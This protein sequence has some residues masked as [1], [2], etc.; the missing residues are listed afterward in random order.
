MKEFRQLTVEDTA[1][2]HKVL[3]DGYALL[4]IFQLPLMPS[5][6]P[7]KNL[8]SGLKTILYMDC[9]LTDN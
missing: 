5:I 7:K 4:K 1:E 9:I 3:I 8:K 2:Y 6:L